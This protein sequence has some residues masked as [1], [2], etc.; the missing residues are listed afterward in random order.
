MVR[1]IELVLPSEYENEWERLKGLFELNDEELLMKL[2]EAELKVMK[3]KEH[4]EAF[5]R[6]EWAMKEIEEFAGIEGLKEFA[7]YIELI[8][9][10]IKEVIE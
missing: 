10:K 1:K 7:K 6:I 8:V 2:I 4:I 9:D 3:T 5:E